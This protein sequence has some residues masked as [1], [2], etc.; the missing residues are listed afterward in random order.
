MRQGNRPWINGSEPAYREQR[1]GK[2]KTFH[3]VT[4]PE[5]GMAMKILGA[6]VLLASLGLVSCQALIY[7]F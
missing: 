2:N 7:A 6:L 1:R 4:G 3:R 5:V